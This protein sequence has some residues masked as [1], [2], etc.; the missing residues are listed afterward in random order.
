MKRAWLI[1]LACLLSGCTE[2]NTYPQLITSNAGTRYDIR[3]N[4][5]GRGTAH[6]LN[7]KPGTSWCFATKS[8]SELR[9]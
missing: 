1:S 4:Q 5:D 9:G 2:T 6:R 3:M 8:I 7:M